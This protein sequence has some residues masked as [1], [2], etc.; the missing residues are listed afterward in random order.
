MTDVVAALIEKDGKYLIAQR[1]HGTYNGCWEF[2]G[3]K[4]EE[5]ESPKDAIEIKEELELTVKAHDLVGISNYTGLN[6]P[7]RL[8]LYECEYV[9]GDI[10]LNQHSDYKFVTKDELDNYEYCDADVYFIDIIKK[11]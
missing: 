2:P 11:R 5:G 3:G 7:I 8:M 9:S 10:T 1:A 4:I 6:R